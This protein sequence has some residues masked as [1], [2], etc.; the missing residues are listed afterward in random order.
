MLI[1]T[2]AKPVLKVWLHRPLGNFR[3]ILKMSTTQVF[4]KVAILGLEMLAIPAPKKYGV[5]DGART[6]NLW[7]HSPAL[8]PLSYIYHTNH[9]LLT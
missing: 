8:S 7:S 2:L 4:R 9:W 3:C 6:R 1:G 5:D